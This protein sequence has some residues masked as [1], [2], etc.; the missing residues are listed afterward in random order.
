MATRNVAMN[1]IYIDVGQPKRD[2]DT[3]ISREAFMEKYPEQKT[4][5][6][7][8]T[9]TGKVLKNALELRKYFAGECIA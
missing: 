2:C 1:E 6:Y 8:I 9:D 4:L 7:I 5:P 3:F